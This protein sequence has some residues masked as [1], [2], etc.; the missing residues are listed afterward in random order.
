[1]RRELEE[2]VQIYKRALLQKGW[3]LATLALHL[4]GGIHRATMYKFFRGKRHPSV[5]TVRVVGEVL[6]V[7]EEKIRQAETLVRKFN[8][9]VR[10]R[11]IHPKKEDKP[12]FESIGVRLKKAWN[13][14]E[15]GKKE[16]ENIDSDVATILDDI[17]ERIRTT[18]TLS[19]H[20][21]NLL[22]H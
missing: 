1:M 13:L 21:R 11:A 6:G 15:L 12:T 17:S 22:K 18:S 8:S 19:N 16:L 14:F 4:D 5:K 2:I 9:E 7:N 3:D 10:S 20:L